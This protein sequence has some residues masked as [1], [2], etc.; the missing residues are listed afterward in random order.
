VPRL[1]APTVLI[2]CAASLFA[3]PT[4]AASLRLPP[5]ANARPDLPAGVAVAENPKLRVDADQG[6]TGGL[7]VASARS[8]RSDD[9]GDAGRPFWATVNICDTKNSPN[10]LGIRTSVPGNGTRQRI[11][12]RYTAQWWSEADGEWL[13]VEGSGVTPWVLV[14]DADMSS[15]QAGWTFTFVQPPEGTTY[16]MRGVVELEW[17]DTAAAAKRVRRNRVATKRHRARSSAH[18]RRG[19]RRS[20]QNAVV[21]RRTLLTKTGM[22]GVQGGDPAGL[23][24][25]MCLIW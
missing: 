16:V 4:A 3:A 17:R 20:Q 2:A 22:K 25:A 21:Q 14:G 13:T 5:G 23:S 24:K 18:R 12:A 11:F 8:N 7:A 1:A 9:A 10:A 19:A 6:A 15:R